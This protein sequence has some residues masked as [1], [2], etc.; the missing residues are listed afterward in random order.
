[1]T[2][3]IVMGVSGTGK[4][5]IAE[6][7]SEELDWAFAEAD[8]F[9]SQA[10]IAK[11]ASSTP[12]VDHDRWPWLGL[13]AAFLSQCETDG[14]NVIVTCSALKRAYRDVLRRSQTRV[15]FVHL[16]ASFDVIAERVANR[17]GHYMP[18]KLLD[19]QFEILQPLEPDEEGVVIDSAQ[20]PEEIVRQAAAWVR[21]RCQDEQSGVG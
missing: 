6:A 4:T 8:E 5:T 13:I 17:K 21:D 2:A 16:D 14:D 18:L 19:S 20:S 10:N 1:M 7:L 15:L 9:H 12:L 11:M 3:V